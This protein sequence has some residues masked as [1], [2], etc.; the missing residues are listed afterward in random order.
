MTARIL[1]PTTSN[2]VN[3]MYL[4]TEKKGSEFSDDPLN[5]YQNNIRSSETK[6]ASVR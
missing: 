4:A 5:S 1:A 2:E 6:D 3:N